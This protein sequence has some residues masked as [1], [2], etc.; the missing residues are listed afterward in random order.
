MADMRMMI[1]HA[2]DM[3]NLILDPE[4]DSY[5]LVDVT[6]LALPQTQDRLAAVMALGGDILNRQTISHPERQ[7]M[8]IYATLLK[9]DDLDRITDSL[10]TS[11]NAN[12]DFYG[13]SANFQARV[14]PAFKEYSAAAERFIDLTT[15]L[16][17][18]RKLT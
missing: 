14:P 10:Q 2:G 1:T 7:Q 13:G 3:S 17:D 9:E 16:S 6:L 5:Y 12:P 8:A 15:R 18:R 11:L 4:L